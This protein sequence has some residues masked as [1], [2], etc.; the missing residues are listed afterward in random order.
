MIGTGHPA[1][2][3]E[4][5]TEQLMLAKAARGL[6]YAE[7]AERLGR[8]PIWV[9][10]ALHGQATM[11]AEEAEKTAEVLGLGPEVAAALQ[12]VPTR[13]TLESAIPKDPVL[14]RLYELVQVYGT[15]IKGVLHEMFGDGIISAI[16]CEIELKRQEDP[17]GDRAV[18]TVNG[19][20]LPYKKW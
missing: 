11:S 5:A 20:F 1:I 8:H 9:G 7:I 2:S 16:D 15:A 19:K 4:A 10:A 18:L 6:T 3:R 14:Y 13:G 12:Q 17:K